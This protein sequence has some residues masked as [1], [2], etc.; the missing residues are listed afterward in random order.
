MT[1]RL[2]FFLF[3]L[4]LLFTII[5]SK[6]QCTCTCC[7]GN[8]CL[9]RYQGSIQLPT[10]SFSSCKR[11]CKLRYPGQCGS[12]PGSVTATCT[13][14]KTPHRSSPVKK[15]TNKLKPSKKQ[16]IRRPLYKTK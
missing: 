6:T 4:F 8:R 11:S 15:I 3:I 1:R 14:T 13:K 7:K 16:V 10:C 2:L 9:Q 5:Q 12:S